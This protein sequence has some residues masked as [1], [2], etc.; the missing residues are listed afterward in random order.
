MKSLKFVV[1]GMCAAAALLGASACSSEQRLE[2]N[3]VRAFHDRLEAGQHDLIYANSSDFLRGQLSEAQFRKFLSQ[4]RSLGRFQDTERAHYTRT[5]VPGQPDL[6]V[7]F[8]NSRY[9]HASCLES[10]TWRVEPGGLKLATYSCAP[11]M[12]VTCQNGQSCETSPV[13]APGFAGLP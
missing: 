12:K 10:F 3:A 9:E 5:K 6:V 11:N 2:T 4:T 7:A 1:S 8:Y 13:P